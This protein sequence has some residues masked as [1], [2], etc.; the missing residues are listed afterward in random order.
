MA[1]VPVVK[2]SGRYDPKDDP[3]ESLLAKLREDIK[4]S[5][6]EPPRIGPA[7]GSIEYTG[8]S[9]GGLNAAM[10]AAEPEAR[11][12]PGL[13]SHEQYCRQHAPSYAQTECVDAKN[14]QAR[15]LRVDGGAHPGHDHQLHTPGEPT[16]TTFQNKSTNGIL[17]TEP[18]KPVQ[19]LTEPV[20]QPVRIVG[21]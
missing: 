17:L 18:G 10:R 12:E 6:A 20:V 15:G 8:G 9:L 13:Q 14:E 11:Q 3:F 7:P 2:P 4:R 5:A 16:F 1:S 19:D 21:R